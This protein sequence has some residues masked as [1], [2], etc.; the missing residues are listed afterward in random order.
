MSITHASTHSEPVLS[1]GVGTTIAWDR[2]CM[3]MLHGARGQML[4]GDVA[5]CEGAHDTDVAGC[6]G[7][8][9]HGD[10]AWWNAADNFDAEIISMSQ[11]AS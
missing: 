9:V 3:V 8:D 1:G 11:A 2:W 5:E 4:H 10:V 7:A 6:E